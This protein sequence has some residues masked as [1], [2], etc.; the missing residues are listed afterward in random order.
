MN[1]GIYYIVTNRTKK[2]YQIELI[3][4]ILTLRKIDPDIDITIITDLHYLTK[5]ID[6][7][8][9][10]QVKIVKTYRDDP[11]KGSRYLK[12]TMNKHTTH[13]LC[14]FVDTDITFVRDFSAIWDYVTNYNIAFRIDRYPNIVKLMN[15]PKND[16]G[17]NKEWLYMHRKKY[18]NESTITHNSGVCV[19]KKSKETDQFFKDWHE[20]WR[21]FENV[22]QLAL[23]RIVKD[24]YNN[25]IN[26]FPKEYN[27]LI[28][29]MYWFKRSPPSNPCNPR[30]IHIH[31]CQNELCIYNEKKEAKRIL[32]EIWE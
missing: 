9:I 8:D 11:F 26:P 24:K 14:M 31:G 22:D 27:A 17:S 20:E 23:A 1:K 6:Y 10:Q 19:W 2:R 7:L 30:L 12:T 29:L 4:S 25:F 21:R 16:W 28:F 32:K 18:I 3:T 13:D 15:G 5:L